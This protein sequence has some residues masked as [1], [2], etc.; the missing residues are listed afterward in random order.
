LNTTEDIFVCVHNDGFVQNLGEYKKQMVANFGIL[1][2]VANAGNKLWSTVIK[3]SAKSKIGTCSSLEYICD[4]I[5]WRTE[6]TNSIQNNRTYD[7]MDMPSWRDSHPNSFNFLLMDKFGR[8]DKFVNLNQI[9]EPGRYLD[10]VLYDAV[11]FGRLKFLKFLAGQGVDLNTPNEYGTTPFSIATTYCATEIIKF[12]AEK[13]VDLNTPD[14]YGNPPILKA[15]SCKTTETVKFFA[16]QG[17]NLNK[18]DRFGATAVWEA[19]RYGRTETVKFLEKQ[20][21]DLNLPDK[22]GWNILDIA[23]VLDH[24]ETVKFLLQKNI[25]FTAARY[26][27]SDEIKWLITESYRANNFKIFNNTE[28]SCKLSDLDFNQD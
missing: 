26:Q 1:S 5:I 14:K 23:A 27:I 4:S 22:W 13:G 15:A 2:Y 25:K 6:N 17:V 7:I 18:P 11:V 24:K 10:H 9:N 28:N 16:E 21:A 8:I 12:L 3:T 20:G 19:A